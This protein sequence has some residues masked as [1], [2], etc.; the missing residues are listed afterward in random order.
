MSGAYFSVQN[1][2]G[3]RLKLRAVWV[4]I[5]ADFVHRNIKDNKN[6]LFTIKIH[7]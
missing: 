1:Y 3:T 6:L 2:I 7:C 4:E 5:L